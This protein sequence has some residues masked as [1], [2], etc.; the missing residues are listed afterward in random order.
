MAQSAHK[1][2]CVLWTALACLAVFV[3]GGARAD[4]R[5]AIKDPHF[6]EV[7]FFFFQENYFSA[8]TLLM[9]AQHFAR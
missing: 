2:V 1:R 8:L 7:L 5:R 4:E 3:A 6:G 9:T